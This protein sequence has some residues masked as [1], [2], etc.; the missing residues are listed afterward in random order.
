M[1][2]ATFGT[3]VFVALKGFGFDNLQSR[4]FASQVMAKDHR[5]V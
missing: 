1:D 5:N 4:L 3:H 2:K